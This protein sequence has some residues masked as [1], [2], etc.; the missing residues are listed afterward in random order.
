MILT[1]ATSTLPEKK[2]PLPAP[3]AHLPPLLPNTKSRNYLEPTIL[4]LQARDGTCTPLPKIIVPTPRKLGPF[5]SPTNS[6]ITPEKAMLMTL[7]PITSFLPL[8][9]KAT[10][11]HP[12][13]LPSANHPL[14]RT[15]TFTKQLITARWSASVRSEARKPHCI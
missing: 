8:A 9:P 6:K 7:S 2:V 13:H 15:L 14:L 4:A 10:G 3:P 11:N 5:R 12:T 1:S